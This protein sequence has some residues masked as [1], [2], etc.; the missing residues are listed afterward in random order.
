MSLQK[1]FA[2]SSVPV[3]S[4]RRLMEFRKIHLLT[5][6]AHA[7]AWIVLTWSRQLFI[8]PMKW[9]CMPLS[10]FMQVSPITPC[11]HL[12]FFTWE[13]GPTSHDPQQQMTHHQ[14]PDS[15]TTNSHKD[16]PTHQRRTTTLK[17]TPT[18]KAGCPQMK[19]SA[20]ECKL[21][22]T[23]EDECPQ[24]RMHAHEWK[25]NA[26]KR[27]WMKMTMHEINA[28]KQWP[29]CMNGH[30]RRWAQVSELLLPLLPSLPHSPSLPPSS[31]T[32]PPALFLHHSPTFITP[33]PSLPPSSLH[34][35]PSPLQ[36]FPLPSW[37][38]TT[39]S[40]LL[41]N[42]QCCK[43]KLYSPIQYPSIFPVNLYWVVPLFQNTN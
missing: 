39:F 40:P 30:G 8:H 25:Q 7:K 38:S 24:T 2:M 15:Y 41:F 4:W 23:N 1:F 28:H 31:I 29:A 16:P 12:L 22:P 34:T 20:H 35:P 5:K 26:H 17:H 19:T 36:H 14:P 42:S 3:K 9:Q 13:A 32:L 18:N 27:K 33:Y 43:I 37:L 11:P 10:L 6:A 21:T